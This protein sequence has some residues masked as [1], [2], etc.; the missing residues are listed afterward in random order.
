VK[1]HF[2]GA[3]RQVTGSR[4]GLETGTM[5][6]QIDCGLFQERAFQKRNWNPPGMAPDKVDALLLTHAHLDHVGLI[7]KFVAAGFDG[8]IY[9]TPPSI[10]L[11]GIVL[12]DSARIQMEDAAYKKRRHKKEKRQGAH[13]VEPLYN[14]KDV[15]KTMKLFRP[16]QYEQPLKLNDQVTAT[17]RESGHILGSASLAIDVASGGSTRRVVFSGDVGQHGKPIIRDPQT[18]D[19]PDVMILESTYG[20]R[21]HSDDEPVADVL[22]RVINKT[23]DRR[24]NILIPTFA[25]ERAQELIYHLGE[26][27]SAGRIPEIPIYLDSPMAVSVTEVFRRHQ[28]LCDA[29]FEARMNR[30]DDPFHYPKLTMVRNVEQSKA[31]N[32]ARPPAIILA[33]SGMC[34]GGR[35]KHHLRQNISKKEATILFCGYQA[36]GTLGR[37]ILDGDPEVRIHNRVWP[38]NAQIER[39]YGMS[40]HADQTDLLNWL[41]ESQPL[42]KRVFLTHGEEDAAKTLARKIKEV[43]GLD[44]DVPEYLSVVNLA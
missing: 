6:L 33:G 27:M 13:P 9:A 5:T 29:E 44:V 15:K 32:N 42:P 31:I 43:H 41:G 35:I 20:N 12:E 23:A 28:G 17:W 37:H 18:F 4:Y 3:N 8:P 30:G 19:A 14:E 22:A 10:E 21:N 34:T 25:I 40:A 7:P 26:L 36:Y 24:G 11:A 16:V 38:V 2:L 1:L 39:I